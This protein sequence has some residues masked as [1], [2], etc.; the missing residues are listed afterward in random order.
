M[1]SLSLCVSVVLDPS[2]R[3]AELQVVSVRPNCSDPVP[4]I[5]T[6]LSV[7]QPIERQNSCCVPVPQ[8]KTDLV[9][10]GSPQVEAEVV[11][12]M[13]QISTEPET[14]DGLANGL[15]GGDQVQP[16]EEGTVVSS[17]V[18]WRIRTFSSTTAGQSVQ[19]FGGVFRDQRLQKNQTLVLRVRW[20]SRVQQ[21]KF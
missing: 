6:H 5:F 19:L 2:V 21:V 3:L 4:A 14:K 20:A 15:P 18:P 17:G 13:T 1:L 12:E 8:E 10:P 9:A 16:E 11:L 7:Q